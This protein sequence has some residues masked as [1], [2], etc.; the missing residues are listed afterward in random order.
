MNAD[1]QAI[2]DRLLQAYGRQHWWPADS[3][4]EVM[5][6][7]I[8]TQ[9]TSWKNVELAIANLKTM[10]MLDAERIADCDEARLGLLIRS[11]GF[12]NQKAT[13]LKAFCRF[14]LDHG[15]QTGIRRL[16]EPRQA[17]LAQHGIGP[18]T[19]DS[20][21]LYALDSPVFVVD[22]YT[23]RIFARLGQT[24]PDAS[25][26]ALQDFFHANLP[27]DVPLFNEYHALIVRHAKE[28]CRSKPDCDG[29]PLLDRCPAG[30]SGAA[31]N[32]QMP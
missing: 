13:R 26:H 31:A 9:N 14:Y 7:A 16:E 24:A 5:V 19:A 17:L 32:V 18:E 25:Y 2:H 23:R 28:H 20:M 3:P 12:F 8:L 27:A 6:G 4:F 22:A 29:C 11:A 21:L 15:G 30:R 10:G 1:V